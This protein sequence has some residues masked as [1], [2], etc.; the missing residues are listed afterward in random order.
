MTPADFKGVTLDDLVI[1]EQVFSLNVYVYDLQETE[2]GDIAARLVQRFPYSY[3]ETMNLNLYEQHFNYVSNME[4]YSH[5]YLC[6]NCDQL[7]KHVGKLHRHERTCTGDVIYKYPSGAY[8]TA[9]TVFERLEDEDIDVPEEDRYYPYRA[10]YDIEVMLQ[11]TDKRRTEKLEWTSHHVLL[12]VFVCSNFITY[13][14]PICFVMKGDTS[15]TVESCLQH[16]TD[17]S[18]KAFRLLVPRYRMIFEEIKQRLDRDLEEYK[19]DEERER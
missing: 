8:H 5:S 15:E 7:R 9:K 4:K 3:Q 6:S 10:T 18:E 11:P 19:D 13:T 1:L 14:E 12:S 16:L 17:I 2:A